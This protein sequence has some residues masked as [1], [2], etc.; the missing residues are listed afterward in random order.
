ME[1]LKSR[2]NTMKLHVASQDK[3][4][5]RLLVRHFAS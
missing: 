4:E 2:P 1:N 3:K 5:S